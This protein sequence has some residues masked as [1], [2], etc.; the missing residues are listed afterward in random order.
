[1]TATNKMTRV[2]DLSTLPNGIY[3]L[4]VE[5]DSKSVVKKVVIDR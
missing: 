3:H 5:G 2:I 4:K 1:V